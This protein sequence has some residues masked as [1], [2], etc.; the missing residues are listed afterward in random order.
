MTRTGSQ[1]PLWW[2]ALD[3]L[4]ADVEVYVPNRFKDGYGPNLEAYKRL[5]EKM[6][7]N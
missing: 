7:P 5:I 4:G 2:R 1:V 6:A 3:D